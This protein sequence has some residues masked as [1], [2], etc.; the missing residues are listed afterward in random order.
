MYF[1]SENLYSKKNIHFLQTPLHLAVIIKSLEIVVKLLRAGASP[2][3][4]DRKGQ[5]SI[6]LCIKHDFIEGL[7]AL[8]KIPTSKPDLDAKN[9]EGTCNVRIDIS[10]NIH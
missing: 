1:M 7:E 9:Y 4:Q 10:T 6:H 3:L 8:I 5:S 2:C